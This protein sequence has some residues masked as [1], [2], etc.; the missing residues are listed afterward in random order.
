MTTLTYRNRRSEAV[1]GNDRHTEKENEEQ[2]GNL[3]GQVE[4]DKEDSKHLRLTLM[5]EILLLG[6]KDKEGYTSFWNDCISSGL[7]GCI[8]IELAFRGRIHLEPATLRK[9]KMLDR[10]VL[11]KSDAPTGDV[12]LDEALKHIKAT[13]PPENVQSWIE[14]LTGETWNPLKLHY[15]LRNVRER[16]AKNLVEKGILTTEKQN[17]LLFDMTTHPVTNTTEKQ[18]LVKRL[19]DSLLERWVNDAHRM[20]R[21]LLALIVLANASDVLENI[22]SNLPDDKYEVA[23]TRSRELLDSNPDEEGNKNVGTEMIWAVLAAFNQS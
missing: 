22:F 18:R 14:F 15:Q 5:E 13:S 7:R 11:L 17:F 23:V 2:S 20:D 1:G 3:D 19:Q 10:K 21:R 9:K 16:L 12:L 6:L 4:E 8:L